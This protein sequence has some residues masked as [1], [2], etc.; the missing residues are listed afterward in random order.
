M[1]LTGFDLWLSSRR[2][3]SLVLALV[4]Y[5]IFENQHLILH[6]ESLGMC[7][8]RYTTKIGSKKY[9]STLPETEKQ[10]IF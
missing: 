4:L 6:P 2:E 1:F 5:K 3:L 10:V 7:H 9:D 8:L